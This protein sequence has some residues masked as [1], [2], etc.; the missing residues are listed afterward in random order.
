[1]KQHLNHLFV[2]INGLIILSL[3]IFMS[4]ADLRVARL[5][6][7]PSNQWPGLSRAPWTFLYSMAPVPGLLLAG[8]AGVVLLAGFFCFS[9]RKFRRQSLFIVLL[10]ALGPGLVVNVILKDHFG[11]PRPSDLI[12]FGGTQHFVQFWQFGSGGKN[13]SFPS[14]HASIAFFLMALWFIYRWKNRPKALFFLLTGLLFGLLVGIARI[15]QG[16]HF[17]SDVLWAGGLVYITGELL[18]CF[19]RFDTFD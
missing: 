2:V 1:M 9:L 17:L 15:M 8:G 12:E 10:L 5:V 7:E 14:G 18:S 4:D 16:A 13:S 19:F 3:L 11:R 6:V